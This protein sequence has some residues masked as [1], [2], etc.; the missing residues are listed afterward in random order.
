[1]GLSQRVNETGWDIHHQCVMARK[2]FNCSGLFTFCLFQLILIYFLLQNTIETAKI[3]WFFYH[4]KSAFTSY[5]THQRVKFVIINPCIPNTFSSIFLL[6]SVLQSQFYSF[7]TFSP[8]LCFAFLCSKQALKGK[9]LFYSPPGV[10]FVRLTPGQNLGSI[11]FLKVFQLVQSIPTEISLFY[12]SAYKWIFNIKFF[13]M[14]YNMMPYAIKIHYEFFRI[15]FYAEFHFYDQICTNFFLTYENNHK[16][17]I[18][19]L[20]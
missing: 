16:K 15:S 18:S 10:H 14:I 7:S 17:L 12:F 11:H 13:K 9:C 3:R 2:S 19:F 1:M 4:P 6:S 5:E 20:T 8:F